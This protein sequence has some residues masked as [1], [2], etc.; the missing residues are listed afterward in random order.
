MKKIPFEIRRYEGKNVIFIDNQLFDWSI[1]EEAIEKI[2]KI[3]D[4][5]ELKEINNNIRMFL[6]DCL[7]SYINKQINIRDVL[8]ALKLGYIE[9]DNENIEI[10][11]QNKQL[12][13]KQ[14]YS[15]V[16]R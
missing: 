12:L 14:N 6:L 13:I 10:N 2:S 16:P 7:G 1:E 3:K 11:N 8:D 4:E 5:I 15:S 9:V